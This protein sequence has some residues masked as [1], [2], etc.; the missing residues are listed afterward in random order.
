[1]NEVLISSWN[2]MDT[3]MLQIILHLR[4]Y[5]MLLYPR[6]GFTATSQVSALREAVNHMRDARLAYREYYY[7]E[8]A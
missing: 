3:K 2:D 4:K 1:M 5:Q 8:D 7:G 6:Y